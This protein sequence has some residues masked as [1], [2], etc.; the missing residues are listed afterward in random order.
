MDVL[1]GLLTLVVILA[2]VLWQLRALLSLR[3]AVGTGVVDASF[4]WAVLVLLPTVVALMA[5][6]QVLPPPT[7]RIVTVFL[8][9]CWGLTAFRALPPEERFVI[10]LPAAALAGGSLAAV[11]VALTARPMARR[12]AAAAQAASQGTDHR[13]ESY[14]L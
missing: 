5:I 13:A 3:R 10:G 8:A 7:P 9:V 2:G 6:A 1:L 12:L 4:A 14:K 11:A